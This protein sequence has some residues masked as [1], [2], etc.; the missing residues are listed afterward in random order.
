MPGPRVRL[1]AGRRQPL[2]RVLA[3]RLQQP[4][5]GPRI[6]ACASGAHHQERLLH[7]APQDVQ[8]VLGEGL[9]AG[10]G[11]AHRLGR[12]QVE[13]PGEDGQAPEEGALGGGQQV[14]APIQGGGASSAGGWGRPGSLP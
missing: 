12:R 7:Q 9:G 8:H 1:L 3:Y 6:P 5:A 11:P 14:V 10:P 4:V 13:V 2:H